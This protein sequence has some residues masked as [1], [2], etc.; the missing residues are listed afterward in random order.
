MF[1]WHKKEKPVFTGIARGVG[2]FGFGGSAT[3]ATGASFFPTAYQSLINSFATKYY[4]STSGSDSNSGT[5]ASPYATIGKA[6]SVAGNNQA[7]IIQPGSYTVT[8]GL[9]SYSERMFDFST[10]T[11]II[12]A[13]GRVT[14]TEASNLGA[15]DNHIFGMRNIGCKI[16]GLII[17]RDNNG[18]TDNYS[19]AMWGY[20]A[21]SM[22]GEVYNCAMQELNANG[23]MSHVYDNSSSGVGR[24]YN[25]T[26]VASNW[27]SSYSGG[28]SHITQNT[29][30]T[31]SNAFSLLGTSTSN[32]NGAT[33]NSTTYSLTNYSN[34]T[35]GVYSGTYAWQ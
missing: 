7:I 3:S 21:T 15:R 14:V 13:P 4:V 27:V 31:S 16:Y 8:N 23:I 30:L 34:S 5:E 24:L 19:N 20:D 35:Y 18:R 2:G 17:K 28:S 32:V 6:I 25:C 11:T 29:A 33:I 26:I 1:E 10:T 12:G 9:G 22:Y